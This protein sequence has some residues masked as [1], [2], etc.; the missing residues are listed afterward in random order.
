MRAV[1]IKRS[2]TRPGWLRA[3]R[4]TWFGLWVAWEYEGRDIKLVRMEAHC[5]ALSYGR[6]VDDWTQ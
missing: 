1:T 5:E 4:L 2:P 3:E 6:R